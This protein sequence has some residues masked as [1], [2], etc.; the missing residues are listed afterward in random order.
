MC[1]LCMENKFTYP[2][3]LI[4]IKYNEIFAINTLN[5]KCLINHFLLLLWLPIELDI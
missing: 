5:I 3:I 1:R 2:N 4:K